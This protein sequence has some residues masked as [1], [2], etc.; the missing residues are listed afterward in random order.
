MKRIIL[1]ALIAISTLAANAQHDYFDKYADM[2][3][4]TSVYV[5]KTMF[6]FMKG[7][8]IEVDDVDINKIISKLDGLY[9]LTTDKPEIMEALRKETAFITKKEDFECIKSKQKTKEFATRKEANGYEE[10]VRVKEDG[11]KMAIYMKEE[12][13]NR[14]EYVM[15]VDSPGD[16]YVIMIF[17]GELL[18]RDVQALISNE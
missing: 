10:I 17:T 7:L 11:Q 18:P 13:G 12:E 4:V 15:I 2:D 9:I 8:P 14:T 5:S 16:E 1:S 6:R 3:G